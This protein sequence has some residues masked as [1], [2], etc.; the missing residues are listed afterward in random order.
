MTFDVI[1]N[2]T[3]PFVAVGFL[4]GCLPMV[5]GLGILTLINILKKI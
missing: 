4:L 2:T 1:L 5:V 3:V